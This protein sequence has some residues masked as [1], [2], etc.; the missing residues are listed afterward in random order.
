[1]V[2]ESPREKDQQ[3][4]MLQ[5]RWKGVKFNQ[6]PLLANSNVLNVTR[7]SAG[8]FSGLDNLHR[9]AHVDTL[10]RYM[11]L[12]FSRRR[13]VTAVAS[14]VAAVTWVISTAGSAPGS[15]DPGALAAGAASF[16]L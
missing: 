12:S 1:M 15:T 6:S 3:K 13:T 2:V 7:N 10:L 9:D 14:I 16:C 8:S 5:S 4:I 11:L